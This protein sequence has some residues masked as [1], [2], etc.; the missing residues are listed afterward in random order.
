MRKRRAVKDLVDRLMGTQPRSTASP[1]FRTTR[2]ALDEEMID[3]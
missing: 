3:A 2:Q 1:S